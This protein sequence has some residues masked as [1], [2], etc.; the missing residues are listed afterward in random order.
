MEVVTVNFFDERISVYSLRALRTAPYIEVAHST[1]LDTV[2]RPYGICLANMSPSQT[3]DA[4]G[5]NNAAMAEDQ[6]VVNKGGPPYLDLRGPALITSPSLPAH[7]RDESLCDNSNPTHILISTHECSYDVTSGVA[8]ATDFIRGKF[9]MVKG[10]ASAKD[11]KRQA[12]ESGA[13]ASEAGGALFAFE[14]PKTKQEFKQTAAWKRYTL[15]RGFKVRGFG[16]LVSP[17]APGLPYVF[18]FPNRQGRT[19][20]DSIHSDG[21]SHEVVAVPPPPL[22]LLAGDCTGSA[23]VFAPTKNATFGVTSEYS[24]GYSSDY[25]TLKRTQNNKYQ[26]QLAI[27]FVLVTLLPLLPIALFLLFL[28]YPEKTFPALNQSITLSLTLTNTITNT[29]PNPNPG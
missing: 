18:R 17:G 26:E 4:V 6:G 16:G 5:D 13:F 21:N 29:N 27:F 15:F 1:Y 14:I 7:P 2:G 11:T 19:T 22:I 24:K 12:V 10:G 23:Y 8:M 28:R 25:S 20:P 9:P 3:T